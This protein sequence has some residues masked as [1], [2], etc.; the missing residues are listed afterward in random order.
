MLARLRCLRALRR[1]KTIRKMKTTPQHVIFLVMLVICVPTVQ[2]Q[3]LF[4]VDHEY[5]Q[6]KMD[7]ATERFSIARGDTVCLEDF[8]VIDGPTDITSGVYGLSY[9]GAPASFMCWGFA[10]IP[11][12]DLHQV[13][14]RDVISHCWRVSEESLG[15]SVDIR[16]RI[17][18]CNDVESTTTTIE[19]AVDG[20]QEELVSTTMQ[21][22]LE[23]MWNAEEMGGQDSQV[24]KEFVRSYF[25]TG[26][27]SY[28]EERCGG[29]SFSAEGGTLV[30]TR[31]AS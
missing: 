4:S 7:E 20:G 30:W 1:L 24:Y 23:S 17:Q 25:M 13:P 3:C 21:Y 29:I 12:A 26:R 28:V 18:E 8:H 14:M 11:P 15:R 16:M 10:L 2:S 22:V 27:A 19:F 6:L 31:H 5:A 9:Q